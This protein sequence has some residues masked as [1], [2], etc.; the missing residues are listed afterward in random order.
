MNLEM[1]NLLDKFYALIWPMLRISAF[2][3]FA[4]IF[5]IRAV[6]LRIRMV[7]SL[8]FSFFISM[9]ID[10]PVIDPLTGPGLAE[11]FNQV[12]IGFAMGMIMQ[13]ATAGVVVAGQVV[14]GSMGLTMA[15]LIDPNVG[16]VPVIS[17]L[18]NVL[19]TLLFLAMGGPLIVF[20]ILLDS[21]TVFPIGKNLM[22]QDV[23]GKMLAWSAMMFLASVLIALPVLMPLLFVTVGLG[24]VTRAAL[25]LNIF[26]VGFSAMLMAGFVILWLALPSTVGR[27]N[28]LWVQ[29]YAQM[30]ALFLG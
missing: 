26:S 4:S 19:G 28:W 20:G 3:A 13:I 11:I 22:S 12:F 10:I 15:T 7:L 2:L 18:F 1:L 8:A 25:S 5:S 16:N 29:T 30:R 9:Q 6:N 24:F 14:S 23:Y 21:F 27:M 17:G